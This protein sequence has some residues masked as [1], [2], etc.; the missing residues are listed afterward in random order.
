ME[1]LEVAGRSVQEVG[2]FTD[3]DC[4]SNAF[5]DGSSIGFSMDLDY[6]AYV[7]FCN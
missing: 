1:E 5:W 3:L 2:G 4:R 7:P 6:L